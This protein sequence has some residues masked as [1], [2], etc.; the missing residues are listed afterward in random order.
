MKRVIGLLIVVLSL[1]TTCIDR[2]YEK[3]VLLKNFK[4]PKETHPE[5]SELFTERYEITPLE[6]RA[7]C[8]VG[9]IDKIKK[10]KGHYYIS[11]SNRSSILHFD[12]RG[13]FVASLNKQGQGPE[14][15]HAI[16]DF[17]VY[18]IDG[19]KEVW[20]SDNISLKVYD[21]YDCSFKRAVSFPFVIY[22]FRRLENSHLLLVTGQNENILTLT[23][24]DGSILSEYLPKEIP[25][26]MFRPVQFVACGTDYLF[27]LGISNAYVAFNRET[28][29]FERG[30]FSTDMSYLSTNQLLE[31]FNTHG[32]DFIREA[33]RGTYINNIVSAKNTIWV[34]TY[35]AEKNYLTKVQP[36]CVVSTEFIYGSILSTVSVG[37]SDDSILLYMNSDQLSEFDENAIDKFGNKIVCNIEDNPCILEFF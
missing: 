18:E 36:D 35:N 1:F 32:V 34:Q 25:F 31:L 29:T 11:L 14:E 3:V 20:I 27:Q 37:D 33:N 16:E 15:Y 9:Q 5:W 21:A 7:D 10:F 28:E 2:K 13:K 19:K 23:D 30:V 8:L 4:V 17:D 12:E 24:K 6:T 22:K 26:I